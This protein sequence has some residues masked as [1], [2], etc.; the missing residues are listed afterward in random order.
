MVARMNSI[1]ESIPTRV[2][3]L[4]DTLNVERC[5]YHGIGTFDRLPLQGQSWAL[6]WS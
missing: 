6:S 3:V 2:S 4:V 5:S 1:I